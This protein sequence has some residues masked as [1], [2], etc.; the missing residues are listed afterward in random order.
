MSHHNEEPVYQESLLDKILAKEKELEDAITQA[1]V[2]AEKIVQDAEYEATE[3]VNAAKKKKRQVEDARK[4][5][6]TA[7]ASKS[8]DEEQVKKDHAEVQKLKAKI[9]QNIPKAVSE[10]IAVIMPS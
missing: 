7:K 4:A 10:I 8:V 2:E 9:E 6:L 1:T 5:A 3:V